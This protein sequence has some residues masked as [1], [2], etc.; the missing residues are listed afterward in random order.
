MTRADGVELP[1][2]KIFVSDKVSKQIPLRGR[3][4]RHDAQCVDSNSGDPHCPPCRSMAYNAANG[5]S[6]KATR[7]SDVV[8]VLLIPGNAGGGKDGT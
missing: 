6:Q 3:R 2:G 5:E 4:A 8:V 1:E 7:E